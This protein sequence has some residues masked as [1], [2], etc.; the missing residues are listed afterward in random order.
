[1]QYSLLQEFLMDLDMALT[2]NDPDKVARML[3]SQLQITGHNMSECPF[4]WG[5]L[6]YLS[7]AGYS[8]VF[9]EV[10][11][12]SRIKVCL[13]LGARKEVVAKWKEAKE[14]RGRLERYLQLLWDKLSG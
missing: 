4:L 10:N 2:G 8:R 1:M 11:S 5:E 14:Q 13:A 9:A 7:D 6:Y 3:R 12:H